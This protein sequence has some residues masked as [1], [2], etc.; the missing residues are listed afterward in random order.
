MSKIVDVID[1]FEYNEPAMDSCEDKGKSRQYLGLE[2]VPYPR[3]KICN[4]NQC[5]DSWIEHLKYYHIFTLDY[6]NSEKPK[7][8]SGTRLTNENKEQNNSC[9]SYLTRIINQSL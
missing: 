4:L 1:W 2:R 6:V 8:F 5:V 3:Y 9:I 7:I